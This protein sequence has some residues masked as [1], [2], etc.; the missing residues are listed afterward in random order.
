[1]TPLDAIRHGYEAYGDLMEQAATA[2]ASRDELRLA[3]L[4]AAGTRLLAEIQRRWS[5][6]REAA[7]W[8][9]PDASGDLAALRLSITDALV[10]VEANRASLGAWL[11][12]TGRHLQ[13]A[14][15]GRLAISGYRCGREDD[16]AA[17]D[18]VG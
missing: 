16:L 18:A 12:D 5:E 8:E 9:R 3:E 11:D 17:C 4:A 15:R 1:M 6:G 7:A 14:G 10:L 2:I 13:A